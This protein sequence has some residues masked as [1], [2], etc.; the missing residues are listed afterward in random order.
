MP[1]TFSLFKL[2]FKLFLGCSLLGVLAL[3]GAYY[4]FSPK[5]PDVEQLRDVRFQTP[6]RIYSQDQKLIAEFGEKRRTPISF[7]Q[8]PRPFIQ[9]LTAAEDSRFFEHFGID[10][11]GL[12]RAAFQLATTGQI[13]S[14]GS[15]ITMQVAKT[16]SS[17]ANAHSAVSSW[18]SSSLCV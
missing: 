9:A 16:S 7:E 14:G 8:I 13:Q 3:A 6:L 2:L 12:F 15:T 10:I 11:K 1:A 18:R 5:L 4:H 17:P